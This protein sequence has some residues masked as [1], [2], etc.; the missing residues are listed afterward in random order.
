MCVET[1]RSK[2]ILNRS[3]SSTCPWSRLAREEEEEEEE[4]GKKV[5]EEKEKEGVGVVLGQGQ[6]DEEQ[7]KLRRQ[8]Y[9][10]YFERCG[11]SKD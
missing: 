9:L 11:M 10:V 6:E 4:E 5:E 8:V 7:E 1:R 2:T 3:T